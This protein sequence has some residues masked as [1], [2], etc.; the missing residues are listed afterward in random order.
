MSEAAFRA[1]L[2]SRFAPLFAVCL[3]VLTAL[4]KLGMGAAP[5]F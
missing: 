2:A 1:G 5:L 4:L 3:I